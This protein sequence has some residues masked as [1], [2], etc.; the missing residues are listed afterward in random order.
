M[1]DL[2]LTCWDKVWECL[3]SDNGFGK[4]LVLYKQQSYDV[5]RFSSFAVFMPFMMWYYNIYYVLDRWDQIFWDGK[6]ALWWWMI[7]CF[8]I[9]SV[10]VAIYSIMS[11]LMYKEKV[12]AKGYI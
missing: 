12:D 3:K 5:I 1:K 11:C 6:P 8:L 10:P 9:W 2:T 4:L 7:F